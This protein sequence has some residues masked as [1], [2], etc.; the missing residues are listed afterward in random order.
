VRRRASW[1]LSLA[2]VLVMADAMTANSQPILE[3]VAFASIVGWR[4]DDHDSAIAAFRHSCVEIL[5]AGKAFERKAAFGGR[6]EQW[7]AVCRMADTAPNPRMFFEANFQPLKVNDPVRGEGLFTGYYEPEAEGSRS[8][9]QDYSV[10]IYRKPAD[11]VAFD[12]ATEKQLGLKYGRLADGRPVAYFTRR[13]I[14]QGAL[15]GRGL[16][17]AWLRD[18][19]DA[20]FIHVQGSGRVRLP[21]GSIIRLAYGGKTG[22][23]YTGIGGLLAERGAFSREEMSM[24][25]TRAWMRKD[26]KAARE[27]MWENKS[28][29]FFREVEVSGSALGPPGAQ[30]VPLTPRRSLAV[31]RSLWMFGTPIWLDTKTP[32]GPDGQMEPFR[33]LMVAQD[34]GTAIRGHVRGDVFWGAGDGAALTAGHMKSAGAMIVLLPKEVARDSLASP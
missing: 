23:P 16:E 9:S 24:Q 14:E 2:A 18:W 28:F 26:A 11:L 12:D 3:P 17:I 5:A 15:A 13:E 29:I 31:D 4:D 8:P 25:A 10:P 30:K 20:F 27:L 22:Q 7:L 6:R 19:A 32:S 21:D 1:L 34:T 33:H